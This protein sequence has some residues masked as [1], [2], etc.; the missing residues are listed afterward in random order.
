MNDKPFFTDFYHKLSLW[1]TDVK[2]HEVTQVVEL[3]EQ[4]KIILAAAEAIPEEKLTQFID[5]FIYDLHEFYRQNQEQAKHS[6][7]LALM[8]ESF[9]A[10]MS[11]VTDKS[12]V[13]WAELS[14]DFKHNGAYQEGDIVGFGKLTCVKCQKSL[15]ISHLTTV[16]ACLYCHHS[17]FIR[18]SLSP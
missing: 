2:Q 16:N 14:E 5:N 7:F 18:E 4:A 8:N 15:L 3:V 12:Q 11:K 9:W 10:L 1:L 13:E 6:I 17:H